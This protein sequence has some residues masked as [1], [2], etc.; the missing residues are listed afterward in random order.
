MRQAM[1]AHSRRRAESGYVLVGALILT[2][3]VGLVA[4]G[5]LNMAGGETH[6]TQTD[7][8]SQRAFW[9]AEA[10]KERSIRWMTNRFRPPD[11]DV[12]PYAD[13]PGPHGGTYTVHVRV[14]TTAHF[15]TEK[16]FLIESI[17]RSAG[18]E[19]RIEQRIVMESFAKYAYFTVDE[20]RPGGGVI[21]FAGADLLEGLVH[22]NGTIHIHG[23]PRFLSRVTS[24]SDH[25]VGNPSY[26]VYE[27]AGWP[28]GSNAPT[29]AEGFELNAPEI[30]LPSQTLDLKQEAQFGGLYLPQ[31]S[32]VQLGRTG[33]GAGIATPGWLRHRITLPPGVNPWT[34][35][36]IASLANHVVYC[37]AEVEVMGV[38]DGE[39]TI[40]SRQDIV[41]VDDLTY[42]ASDAAGTPLPGCNDL[43]GLVAEQNIR[44][45]FD[46][47]TTD[48]L[49]VDAVL[50]ALDS[51]I[52]ADSYDNNELRGVLTIWGGLI[53]QYRGPVGLVNGAGQI[54]S[55][56][57][58]NYHYDPRVT[59]RTPPAFPLTGVYREVEWKE[60]WVESNPF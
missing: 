26:D 4:M 8:E 37:D 22:S 7:L 14:D 35:V 47:A 49:I 39:L 58:K 18:R 32:E 6:L 19:R 34:S 12:T 16:A 21:W 57:R 48:D 56:Y 40:A 5:F 29:F 25:M 60:S 43:L 36:E 51:S 20:R 28:V 38:L 41:I 46:H 17:G 44:F 24:A 54:V 10:G 2:F 59:A 31:G 55:G 50:M 23:N 15:E 1:D 11:F 27:P 13:E 45:R 9:L 42:L 33:V 3:A 53:Q 52:T 30:T